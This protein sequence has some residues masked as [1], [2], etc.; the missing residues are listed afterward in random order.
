MDRE[1]VRRGVRGHDCPGPAC[2]GLFPLSHL[3]T[4]CFSLAFSHS[5]SLS[6]SNFPISFSPLPLS[7]SLPLSLFPPLSLSPFPPLLLSLP[8]FPPPSPSLSPPL[9]LF[10]LFHFFPL[11]DEQ[12]LG[13]HNPIQRLSGRAFPQPELAQAP[14]EPFLRRLH[15]HH[16]PAYPPGISEVVDGSW[17]TAS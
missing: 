2:R 15:W 7:F 8:F 4:L 5:F 16:G 3:L 12:N 17:G 14:G 1:Q 10:S 9:S 13:Q 6:L 11:S